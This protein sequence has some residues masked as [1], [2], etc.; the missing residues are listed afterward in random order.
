MND[1][2]NPAPGLGAG[3]FVEVQSEAAILA[4]LAPDGTLDGLPFMPEMLAHCGKR[5]RVYRR[6]DKTCDTIGKFT[7]L[8]V[9]DA[10]HLE[11][12]RCGGDYHDGC[13]Y[14]CLIFWKEAWLRRVANGSGTQPPPTDEQ[15]VSRAAITREGLLLTTKR[16]APAPDEPDLYVCQATELQRF[17]TPVRWWDPRQYLRELRSGNVG[18]GPFLRAIVVAAYNVA[19]RRLGRFGVKLYPHVAGNLKRTPTSVLNLSP[20]DRVR[21][22]PKSEILATLDSECRNR[23]MRFDVEMVQ[24]CGREFRVLRRA[25]KIIHDRTGRMLALRD[26]IILEGAYCG[27]HLSRDRLLCPRNLFPFWRE[28]WLERVDEPASNDDTTQSRS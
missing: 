26:C 3:E 13:Q 2:A 23:G 27:G 25:D 24:Y 8:Y 20:G 15:A 4:T 9:R 5:F 14:G 11:G 7:S 22:K 10:V 17:G 19:A 1:A 18:I 28:I 16:K 21:V 6:A 12:L